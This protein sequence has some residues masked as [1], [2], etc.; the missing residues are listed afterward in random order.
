MTSEVTD[1]LRGFGVDARRVVAL[2][3]TEA[4]GHR[5]TRV[6][7]EHLLIGLLAVEGSVAAERLREAGIT[8]AAARHKVVE[9][10]PPGD[11]PAPEVLLRSERAARALG[12]SVRFSH[13]ARASSVGTEHVLLGVLD[14]EGTAGQVLRGLGVDVERLRSTLREPEPSGETDEHHEH[15]EHDEAA[16]EPVAAT[17]P[18]LS[19]LACP[20]CAAVLDD[21]IDYRVLIAAGPR[22]PREVVAYSCRVCGRIL[23][24]GPG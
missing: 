5:H 24:V 19:A 6:G 9:A 4:R 2:A 15:D 11:A 17:L 22:G 16:P 10:V 1:E 20:V 21:A 8:L 7:T 18:P 14:V 13:A 3:E 12:R 23:G